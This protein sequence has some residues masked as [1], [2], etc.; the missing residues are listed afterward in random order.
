MESHRHSVFFGAVAVL[1]L[2]SIVYAAGPGE[3]LRGIPYRGVLEQDGNP[4]SATDVAMEFVLYDGE[5]GSGESELWRDAFTVD[6]AAGTFQV[7]LGR[8]AAALPETVFEAREL[9]LAASVEGTPLPGRTQVWAMPQATRAAMAD[10]STT[11]DLAIAAESASNGNFEVANGRIWRGTDPGNTSDLGLYSGV[12][13]NLVRIVS[14][15]ASIAFYNDGGRGTNADV[16]IQGGSTTIND[17]LIVNG[18]VT[19][20]TATRTNCEEVSDACE[21]AG[22]SV[23]FL[24]RMN[25]LTCPNNK[26]LTDWNILN[27]GGNAYSAVFTCCAITVQ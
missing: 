5:Q 26:F 9:W 3:P 13:G 8:G 14:T 10:H 21:T 27:C 6:V 22:D 24:D 1:A 4:I 19:G 18:T 11:S 25:N 23:V 2:C 7:T 17:P 15:N 16:V 20:L 12:N